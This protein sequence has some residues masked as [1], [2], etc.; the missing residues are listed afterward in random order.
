MIPGY[1]TPQ[2]TARFAARFADEQGN[3]FYRQAQA[4]TVSSLGAGTYLGGVEEE[5]TERYKDALLTAVRGG[6]NFIDTSLNYRNQRS[7]QAVERALGVLIGGG[8]A[9]R[10]EIVVCTKA[11]FLVP[12]A[13]P[14]KALGPQD[15]A[16]NAHSMAPAFLRDQLTRSLT[17]LGLSAV[18][19]FY[20]HNPE[21]QLRYVTPDDFYTRIESAF[22]ACEQLVSAGKIRFYGT[23]TWDG[24]RVKE[25]GIS[26]PRLIEIARGLGGDGHHFRFIQLPFNLAMAEAFTER[27]Q[28]GR[29]VLEVAEEAGLTVVASASLLQGK[30]LGQLPEEVAIRLPGLKTDAQRA[31]QFARSTPGT[32]VALVGMSRREHVNE[33]LALTQSRPMRRDEY[34]TL[35]E[36]A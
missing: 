13:V 4:L 31:I 11:G 6:I 16:G 32:T 34:M 29:T 36:T 19:V 27:N 12:H 24:Y 7:E 25:K 2:G 20:L 22:S 26:L 5:I 21:T 3:G 10:D 15:V 8:E 17:N 9:K 30:L 1:A 14:V 35:Y 23:S 28:G 18:D 33:N